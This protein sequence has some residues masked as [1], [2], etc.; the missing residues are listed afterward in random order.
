MTLAVSTLRLLRNSLGPSGAALGR[1]GCR[2]LVKGDAHLTHPALPSPLS[3]C[4]SQAVP[5]SGHAG[6]TADPEGTCGVRAVHQWNKLEREQFLFLC[7]RQKWGT[8]DTQAPQAGSFYFSHSFFS[9]VFF[10]LNDP[11]PCNDIQSLL[12]PLMGSG[13]QFFAIPCVS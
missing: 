5:F 7:A 12:S 1:V 4:R 8:L 9:G 11:I 3:P 6:V 10:P 2:A 13:G